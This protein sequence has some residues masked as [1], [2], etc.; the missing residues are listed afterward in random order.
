ML[1]DFTSW[2]NYL[3]N[4]FQHY[5]AV[6]HGCISHRSQ[7]TRCYFNKIVAV[8]MFVIKCMHIS[9]VFQFHLFSWCALCQY[10]FNILWCTL[11]FLFRLRFLLLFHF[12]SP[13]F[14]LQM[15]HSYFA[16]FILFLFRTPYHF[17]F[18]LPTFHF[19]MFQ[20]YL[21][22]FKLFLFRTTFR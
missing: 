3:G 10:G 12:T 11:R 19:R 18:N 21:S 22:G 15:F 20:S 13:M 17:L 14:H 7:Q 8:F 2:Y 9:R 1:C 16:G 5:A 4:C 6:F